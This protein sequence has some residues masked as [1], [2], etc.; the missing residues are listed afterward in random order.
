MILKRRPLA[1]VG[2]GPILFSLLHSPSLRG[3]AQQGGFRRQFTW[4][5][6]GLAM[7]RDGR[8][9]DAAT[10]GHSVFEEYRQIKKKP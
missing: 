4:V 1:T 9:L 5:R 3:L 6:L 8:G 10:V 7:T 2:P